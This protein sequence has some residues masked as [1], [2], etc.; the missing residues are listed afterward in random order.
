VIWRDLAAR[1][2]LLEL[3]ARGTL[4][5]RQ[6]QLPYWH[7][8]DTVPWT[9][10]TGRR[11][12]IG[13]VE[14]RRPE[15]LD[16]LARAW[17]QWGEVLAALTA[18]GLAPTPDG[19]LALQDAQ[20]AEELPP[21]PPHLN[22]RTAAAFLGQH[23]KV[24]LTERR[25]LHL[26]A[27]APMHDGSVRLRPPVGL[28]AVTPKGTVDLSGIAA[29]LGEVSISERALSAGLTLEGPLRAALLVENLGTF[30][31]LPALDGWLLIHVA[32]WDTPTVARLLERLSH[33]PVVHF[34]DLD[35]NGV[36]IMQHL[37][38]LRPDL[39]WFVPPFWQEL[40]ATKGLAM[41]W[42]AEVDLDDA[43][44]LVHQLARQGLWVEQ[45]SLALD[46]RLPAALQATVI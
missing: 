33:V 37:R 39:R 9:R 43:P 4:K 13:I 18:R 44:E 46:P 23:S 32:G 29:L 20:R 11:D 3:L 31:D 38:R 10:R 16:L 12:E 41:Q 27:V 1:L 19:Y 2:A 36:R 24:V 34:G 21:L 40:V 30:C 14:E 35:P 17:P 42:P 6:A 26:G 8:L 7:E 15:L 28:R 45:E 25:R 22:R 5:Q